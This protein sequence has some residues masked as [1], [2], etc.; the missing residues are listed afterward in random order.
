[1]DICLE[2]GWDGGGERN[3]FTLCVQGE[4]GSVATSRNAD[5]EKRLQEEMNCFLR[6][7]KMCLL[8]EVSP[9]DSTNNDSKPDP[10]LVPDVA[11]NFQLLMGMGLQF[12]IITVV[13]RSTLVKDECLTFKEPFNFI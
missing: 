10:V 11:F 2:W 13:P 1:M 3:C 6:D 7:M 8:V 12:I 5:M 4:S 9:W